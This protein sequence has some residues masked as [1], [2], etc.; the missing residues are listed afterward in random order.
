MFFSSHVPEPQ[1]AT[2]AARLQ[3]ESARAIFLDMLFSSRDGPL[4]PNEFT[5]GSKHTAM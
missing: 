5:A 1:V 2:Y 3:E 4:W